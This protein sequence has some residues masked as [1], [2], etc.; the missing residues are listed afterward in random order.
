MIRINLLPVRETRRKA[1][2]RQQ[3]ILL[4]VA[5]GGGIV[6]SLVLHL[7]I[8]ARIASARDR[9]EST[10]QE[11]ARLEETLGD[12][13]EFRAK[14]KDIQRKLSVI[15]DLEESRRGPVRLMDEI[16]T[17]IPERVWL[18]S[19]NLK[20]GLLELEGFALDNEL[21]AAFMTSL[22]QSASFR[23]VELLESQL[24]DKKSIKYN[25]FKIRMRMGKAKDTAMAEGEK[26]DRSKNKGKARRKQG[27]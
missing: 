10:K 14:K 9:I 1:T 18:K 19:M 26:R 13:E 6:T 7:A 5:V 2:Q 21:V 17:R 16:S 23:D 24:E 8:Q 15:E 20:K 27:R 3:A 25:R 11:L 22:G 12:V 4:G